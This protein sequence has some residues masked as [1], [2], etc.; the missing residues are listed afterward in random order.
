M[1][2][3]LLAQLRLYRFGKKAGQTA[4]KWKYPTKWEP[5]D[6][7]LLERR[8]LFSSSPWLIQPPYVTGVV[9]SFDQAP[10]LA[11]FGGRILNPRATEGAAP[12]GYYTSGTFAFDLAGSFSFNLY[13][14]S[15][16]DLAG[17]PGGGGM[18]NGF[19]GIGP[20]DTDMVLTET[21]TA[22]FTYDLTGSVTHGHYAINRTRF[23]T[24][25]NGNYTSSWPGGNTAG[26]LN[27]TCTTFVGDYGHW[28]TYNWYG[29]IPTFAG[30]AIPSPYVYAWDSFTA[31]ESGTLSSSFA[32]SGTAAVSGTI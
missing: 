22:T 9:P 19:G 5:L 4:P 31:N 17:D 1:L 25:A 16:G 14:H 26:S 18:G 21:G 3:D 11:A 6:F 30:T 12:P 24:T 20:P 7:E 32:E 28:Y 23:S 10:F 29:L 13:A 2:R 8:E 15:N 27:L